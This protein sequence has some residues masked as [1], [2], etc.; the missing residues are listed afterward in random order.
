MLFVLLLFFSHF[1]PHAHI[2]FAEWDRAGPCGSIWKHGMGHAC[3][4]H[5]TP[6][7]HYLRCEKG[8][9]T[10]IAAEGS[11]SC[12]QPEVGGIVSRCPDIRSSARGQAVLSPSIVWWTHGRQKLDRA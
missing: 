12:V 10:H 11:V 3:W 9:Y 4:L 6:F 8:F 5:P 7:T 1:L 2:A